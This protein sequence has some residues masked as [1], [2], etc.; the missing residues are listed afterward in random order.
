MSGSTQRTIWGYLG[1]F[2]LLQVAVYTAVAAGFILI[3][4]TLPEPTQQALEILGPYRPAGWIQTSGQILRAIVIALV[5]YPFYDTIIHGNRGFLVLFGA[6]WGVASVGSV[7]PIPGSIEGVIYTQM[8]ALGHG[9]A[10]AASA[11]EVVVFSWL[12]LRWERGG[13]EQVGSRGE[14]DV[15]KARRLPGFMGR[16]TLL[17]VV[18]YAIAG[19]LLFTVQNYAE[20][21][22]VQEQ[23]AFYRPLDNPLVMAAVP[24][25]IVRGGFLALW[26]FPFR[27]TFAQN[28]G[29]PALFGLTFGLIALASPGFIPGLINDIVVRTPVSEA[30]V[31]PVEIVFQTLL[32]SA[33]LFLWERRRGSQA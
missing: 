15:T 29:W 10:L 24:L 6:L 21:F 1:R 32:F 25:Q 5:L 30:L 33:L 16:F 9:I 17:H 8:T 14:G 13:G 3:R 26:F 12:F 27:D 18:T 7:D 20:A 22:A 31:G 19:I 2:T 28:G 4:Q 23:F 11:I